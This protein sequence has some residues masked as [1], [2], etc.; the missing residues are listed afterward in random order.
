MNTQLQQFARNFLKENLNK[1]PEGNQLI[2]K[3]MYSH[4]KLDACINDVVDNMKEETLDW[5]M[6]QVQNSIDKIHK[7]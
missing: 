6:T 2:F 4:K 7:T 1:L 3:R 5:A